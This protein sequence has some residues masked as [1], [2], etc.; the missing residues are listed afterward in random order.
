MLFL[1]M[2]RSEQAFYSN[3]KDKIRFQRIYVKLNLRRYLSLNI[4][5]IVIIRDC[6]IILK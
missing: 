4:T 1:T 5:M 6:R 2:Q 3:G